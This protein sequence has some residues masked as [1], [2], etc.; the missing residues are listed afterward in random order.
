MVGDLYVCASRLLTDVV[1][2]LA[3]GPTPVPTRRGV[4]A[5]Q[6]PWGVCD[7]LFVSIGRG[8]L[9]NNI[10]IE[11]TVEAEANCGA[12]FMLAN[13]AVVLIRCWP[14]V[15]AAGN[16]PG[17]AAL[18]AAAQIVA[19]DEQILCN[20]VPCRL[21]DQVDDGLIVDYAFVSVEQVGPEGG[22]IGLEAGSKVGF[23]RG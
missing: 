13:I 11:A 21:S 6:V 10:P 20:I 18:D 15:D 22:R 3:A 9:S 23:R 16:P 19:A 8:A 5:G 12:A 14:T 17:I 1:A 7:Q 4:T 2:G